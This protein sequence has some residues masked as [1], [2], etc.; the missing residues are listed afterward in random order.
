MGLFEGDTMGTDDET[1][2]NGFP[3]WQEMAIVC[4]LRSMSHG[5]IFCNTDTEFMQKSQSDKGS[6][7]SKK[8]LE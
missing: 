3:P 7:Q 4:H 1:M 8:Q 2:T 6:L 5:G